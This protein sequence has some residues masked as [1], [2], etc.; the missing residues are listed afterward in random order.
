MGGSVFIAVGTAGEVVWFR[1]IDVTLALSI[2]SGA[3]FSAGAAWSV[4]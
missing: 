3:V 2:T 4:V 1:E